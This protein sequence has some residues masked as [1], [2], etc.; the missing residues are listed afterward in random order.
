MD[1]SSSQHFHH[2]H[3]QGQRHQRLA[4][5]Q[6]AAG[7]S[8]PSGSHS[9][10]PSSPSAS[11]AA[12]SNPFVRSYHDDEQQVPTAAD[13]QPASQ[14]L[15]Q[16]QR[17]EQ[18][19]A[20]YSDAGSTNRSR[21]TSISRT[22]SSSSLL[23]S[24]EIAVAIKCPSL[25][26]DS[27][28]VKVRPSDTVLS[29]KHIIERTWPGAPRAEGMRCIRSGRILHDD[30]IF[31]H[32]T[33]SLEA[34]EPLSLHLVIRPDAW[35]DPLNR[36]TPSRRSSYLRQQQQQ[37]QHSLLRVALG[38]QA[39]TAQGN[40]DD[41]P[42]FCPATSAQPQSETPPDFDA[43]F[44]D[45]DVTPTG[46]EP[47]EA[48]ILG[49][50]SSLDMD[51]IPTTREA[52]DAYAV[53][54]QTLRVTAPD[55]WPM[56]IEALRA[57]CDE[58]VLK[59][60]AVYNEAQAAQNKAAT[61]ASTSAL[62]WSQSSLLTSVETTLLAWDPVRMPGEVAATPPAKETQYFYQQV[63]HR[64]LPYLLRVATTSL[65]SQR[66]ETLHTLL[67]RIST[68]RAMIDKLENIIM[69]G[70]LL[71]GATLIGTSNSAAP[72]A[73]TLLNGSAATGRAVALEQGGIVI[74]AT[75]L[76]QAIFDAFRS[77]T[78][79]DATAVIIPMFF[80]GLKVGI[81]LS[82]MLRGADTTKKYFVLG[83]ASIYIAFESYRIVQRRMRVRQRMLPRPPQSP[84]PH[85]PP[86]AG[87]EN[88]A[89]QAGA[90]A[91]APMGA[92]VPTAPSHEEAIERQ[93]T[94]EPLRPLPPPQAPPR[95]RSRTRF[96]YD[97]WI[98]HMAFIGLDAE[99]AELGLLPAPGTNAAAALAANPNTTSAPA[100]EEPHWLERL[101]ISSWVLPFVLFLVTTM[102]A[103]E[104]RRK[105]AIEERE[106]VI[107]KWT[108]LEQERRER[109]QKL[110]QRQQ[111]KKEDQIAS[112][113]KVAGRADSAHVGP[114]DNLDLQ[115]KRADYAD[116][117]LRQRRT[118]EA[119]DLDDEHHRLAQAMAVGAGDD[120][121]DAM[122]DMNIF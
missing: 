108:R 3:H 44:T 63:S 66:S 84:P 120:H 16:P 46:V 53:L 98:D 101:L 112:Q 78:F 118:T 21:S 87:E 39:P 117:I 110:L 83:M 56:L 91:P 99:D 119:V 109:A 6:P 86:A 58:Y 30:E 28:V 31:S 74:R 93:A 52:A 19:T 4:P 14:A 55:N 65:D 81:L 48:D 35:S 97:W 8:T 32:L 121:D 62:S 45:P 122:E 5:S 22:V 89:R 103:V 111:E 38:T 107:R 49:H 59:Y 113:H 90:P 24:D 106:R 95:F 69:L 72:L 57:A 27:A 92:N 105:R 2:H 15:L 54:E 116:R 77:L 85:A 88:A 47:P 34:D 10:L 42:P 29:L 37:Q 64:G 20:Y 7:M 36:P 80:V 26:K 1:P 41:V 23:R 50:S 96:S 73:A 51:H 114:G 18:A 61:S 9:Q 40:D 102:P 25:D 76:S 17:S 68:L 43:Y 71:R 100:H 104:Q 82:V 12:S 94:E 11:T 115:Q 13:Q 70:R 60:E 75:Q 67:D 33:D 79:A